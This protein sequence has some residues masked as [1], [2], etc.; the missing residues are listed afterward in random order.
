MKNE[1]GEAMVKRMLFLFGG[2]G[3]LSREKLIPALYGLHRSGAWGPDTVLVLADRKKMDAEGGRS[4]FRGA[5]GAALP[6]A[7]FDDSVLEKVHYCVF[8]AA[9]E[10][11]QTALG[12]FGERF[13]GTDPGSVEMLHYLALPPHAHGLVAARLK[14]LG[15][16]REAP[17]WKRLVVE[18]PFGTDLESARAL[19][20][21]LEK[22]FDE[23]RVYRI[24][25]YLGKEM[26]QNIQVIRFANRVFR[27]V[28]NR[29]HIDNIQILVSE[30]AGIGSR[31]GYYDRTGAI[32]DMV[33]S[34]L[35]Q[36]VALVASDMAACGPRE[37]GRG[38]RLEILKSLEPFDEETARKNCVIAQYTDGPG[39]RAYRREEGIPAD[40]LTETYVAMKLFL[41]HESWRGVPFYLRTGKRLRRREAV[42]TA[43][44]KDVCDRFP[45]Y[46][47]TG[48]GNVLVILIQPEEGVHLTFNLKKPGIRKEIVPVD[49]RFCQSC[50][51]PA[52]ESPGAYESLLKDVLDGDRSRFTTWDEI[53]AAWRFVDSLEASLDRRKAL[54]PYA[55]G[56]A[57]PSAARR[58]IR[59]DKR[60]W[61]DTK[62]RMP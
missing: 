15:W 8:D 49:M 47:G 9:C 45:D 26:T 5:V 14:A 13:Y 11:D 48:G 30:E 36:L 62:E 59:A 53:A 16:H 42:I 18:K 29:D 21:S 40:S 60:D 23:D 31:S 19:N 22:G 39:G 2:A 35:L 28:W 41:N 7:G 54:C 50:T 61:W 55:A 51:Y 24:D 52:R 38:N 44:F 20:R 1:K 4:W 43:A 33:Q 12:R 37:G 57:E 56:G 25:H 58:L 10:G 46:E 3:D 32:R 17:G 6:E 34:H 27:D